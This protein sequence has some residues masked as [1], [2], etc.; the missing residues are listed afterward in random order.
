MFLGKGEEDL[1]IWAPIERR[2]VHGTFSA[3]GHFLPGTSELLVMR[4]RCIFRRSRRP[5]VQGPIGLGISG[6]GYRRPLESP[7]AEN[8]LFFVGMCEYVNMRV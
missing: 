2:R 7:E 3:H 6:Y 1:A 5:C 4:P 8:D